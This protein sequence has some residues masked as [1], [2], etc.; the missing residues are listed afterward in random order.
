MLRRLRSSRF[1]A[2]KI[3]DWGANTFASEALGGVHRFAC[4]SASTPMMLDL[5]LW[6]TL[7]GTCRP[8][9]Q[10]QDSECR[11][12]ALPWSHSTTLLRT[13]LPFGMALSDPDSIASSVGALEDC[14]NIPRAPFVLCNA[15]PDRDTLVLPFMSSIR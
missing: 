13:R 10:P 6:R 14:E 15:E 9:R 4:S 3:P 7:L 11:S 5:L 12:K 1:E 8:Q 2:N